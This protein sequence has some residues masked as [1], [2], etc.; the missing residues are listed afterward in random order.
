MKAIRIHKYGG[1]EVL[2]VEEVP[3][4]EPAEGEILVRV[5]AAGVNPVDW[6]VR[7][8]FLDGLLHHKLPFILGWDV[9]GVVESVGPRVTSFHPGPGFSAARNEKNRR[10][11]IPR[12]FSSYVA[13]TI[14]CV[15]TNEA[16]TALNP[17]TSTPRS[18]TM[19]L[20]PRSMLRLS[21]ETV[22]CWTRLLRST[23]LELLIPL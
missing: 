21:P 4:P 6:K 5:H 18:V 11:F 8:G 7:E 22:M 13:A 23:I 9:S 10:G 2:M 16:F 14:D 20:P 17:A 12:R 1:P 19:L 15:Q 3:R